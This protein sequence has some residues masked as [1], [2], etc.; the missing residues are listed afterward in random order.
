GVQGEHAKKIAKE[1]TFA[2]FFTELGNH[3]SESFQ[4][5]S[6]LAKFIYE[7]NEKAVQ[8][9][10]NSL[11]ASLFGPGEAEA[12]AHIRQQADK[13]RVLRTM[14]SLAQLI[15]QID[16]EITITDLAAQA[17]LLAAL[18][19]AAGTEEERAAYWN[20]LEAAAENVIQVKQAKENI[21]GQRQAL[22]HLFLPTVDMIEHNLFDRPGWQV[23]VLD[24]LKYVQFTLL[25]IDPIGSLLS[26]HPED[27]TTLVFKGISREAG[28]LSRTA[29][30]LETIKDSAVEA[31]ETAAKQI[32]EEIDKEES[33]VE[34][35]EI[36]VCR[37]CGPG[38]RAKR[39]IECCEVEPQPGTSTSTEQ[40]ELD[41]NIPAPPTEEEIALWKGKNKQ[42]QP[43]ASTTSEQS[44]LD[45]NIPAPQTEEEIAVVEEREQ[46]SQPGTSTSTEQPALNENIPVLPTR[47][48]ILD[49]PTEDSPLILNADD[50]GKLIRVPYKDEK[51][52]LGRLLYAPNRSCRI[53]I[54]GITEADASELPI[55][56]GL[57]DDN[58]LRTTSPMENHFFQYKNEEGVV[59]P[60][61]E[62]Q[63]SA[64][65]DRVAPVIHRV[66][67]KVTF[68]WSGEG[69][70]KETIIGKVLS[71]GEQPHSFV[72]IS[73]SSSITETDF[74][75]LPLNIFVR[76]DGEQGMYKPVQYV[77]TDE[78]SLD[79]HVDVNESPQETAVVV[80]QKLLFSLPERS[81]VG[82]VEHIDTVLGYPIVFVHVPV[83]P[84]HVQ[85]VKQQLQAVFQEQYFDEPMEWKG[86]LID[87]P[88]VFRIGD[89]VIGGSV[90]VG[91][92]WVSVTNWRHISI[93]P[94][95]V[96]QNMIQIISIALAHPEQYL[97]LEL[98]STIEI[99]D[100]L[101]LNLRAKSLQKLIK[102]QLV[103]QQQIEMLHTKINDILVSNLVPRI[104]EDALKDALEGAL[105][106]KLDALVINHPYYDYSPYQIQN[107]DKYMQK[108]LVEVGAKV[109][110]EV[111]TEVARKS[112]EGLLQNKIAAFG[113]SSLKQIRDEMD[114]IFR[115]KLAPTVEEVFRKASQYYPVEKVVNE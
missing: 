36:Q 42:S 108:Q 26:I 95:E 62:V 68:Q 13:Q 77:Y 22:Q 14:V 21:N 9:V 18:E 49:F 8:A 45:D 3:L 89:E 44:E 84:E 78:I 57:E 111:A 60:V 103:P 56:Y 65:L 96:K 41:D 112:I 74:E 52:V 50:W 102:T 94:D 40:L 43:G 80:G 54:S 71:L 25:A 99:L 15:A 35:R 93:H 76:M 88:V 100:L 23:Q 27:A 63:I 53:S 86:Q 39:S 66:G 79:E 29:T 107:S 92:E 59:L 64:D 91:G 17:Q 97:K 87:A 51:M 67:Q 33:A 114:P 55:I 58:L 69:R 98:G 46:Q 37:P 83:S 48:N 109:V 2:K 5:P 32:R 20:N 6:Q 19:Q 30:K 24:T 12:N 47:E 31:E 113:F 72:R 105:E 16:S 38:G 10:E 115:N 7:G 61:E 82:R 75:I 4:H 81:I 1:P 28:I 85:S 106:D 70:E 90:H 34:E 101:S 104:T 110:C 11:Q 73:V